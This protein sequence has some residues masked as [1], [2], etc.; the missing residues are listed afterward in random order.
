VRRAIQVGTCRAVAPGLRLGE[1][2]AV[3]EAIGA[4]GVSRELGRVP[5]GAGAGSEADLKLSPDPELGAALAQVAERAGM[6]SVCVASTDLLAPLDGRPA[7][8]WARRGAAAVEMASAA[9]FATGPRCGVA[10]AA[11][12]V[13]ADAGE[14]AIDAERLEQAS[15][16]MG[17]LAVE[18]LASFD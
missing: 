15:A 18:A 3:G 11:L 10:V 5:A 7:Q 6:R 14:E 12:L 1:V 17:G 8:D 13:V 9:L 4:D 2:M 16:E